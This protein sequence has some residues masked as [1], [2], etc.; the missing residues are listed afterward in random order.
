MMVGGNSLVEDTEAE[1]VTLRWNMEDFLPTWRDSATVER[2]P[3]STV[4]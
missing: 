3:V 1:V 4:E 2:M